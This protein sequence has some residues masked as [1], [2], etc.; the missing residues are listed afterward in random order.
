MPDRRSSSAHYAA[1]SRADRRCAACRLLLVHL[2]GTAGAGADPVDSPGDGHDLFLESRT[3][4]PHMARFR[5]SRTVRRAGGLHLPGLARHLSAAGAA[6]WIRSPRLAASQAPQQG[7]PARSAADCDP[8]PSLDYADHGSHQRSPVYLSTNPTRHKRPARRRI[9]RCVERSPRWQPAAAARQYQ[10][11]GAGRALVG[12]LLPSLPLQRP[13]TAGTAA[14]SGSLFR[15]WPDIDPATNTPL[16]RISAS[17][18]TSRWLVAGFRYRRRCT[19]HARGNCASADLHFN[20]PRPL[21]KRPL[22]C[23]QARTAQRRPGAQSCGLVTI[24]S[25]PNV[26]PARLA[27]LR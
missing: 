26:A 22:C 5:S 14:H 6:P 24:G 17:G 16:D 3:V 20:R 15:D 4:Q 18:G 8:R 25:R 21:G 1:S 23:R 7:T 2:R 11:D 19:S 27:C 10:R 9:G 13:R 12:T